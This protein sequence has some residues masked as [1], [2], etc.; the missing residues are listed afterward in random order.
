MLILLQKASFY[1]TGSLSLS[2][3]LSLSIQ[4]A[5]LTWETYVYIAK[6]SEMDK[7]KW[8]KQQKWTV[9]ITLTKVP[10]E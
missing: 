3:S 10:K 2:R 1:F 8:N 9:N 6:A 7:Q 4:G 5:L